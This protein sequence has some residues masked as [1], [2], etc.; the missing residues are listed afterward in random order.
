MYVAHPATP[1][2]EGA[3]PRHPAAPPLDH[4][5]GQKKLLK[6]TKLGGAGNTPNWKILHRMSERQPIPMM[7]M[8]A[9]NY[10]ARQKERVQ[11]DGKEEAGGL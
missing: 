4:L 1:Q 6:K 9:P 5:G 11:G 2:G 3:P 10:V 8:I 7:M